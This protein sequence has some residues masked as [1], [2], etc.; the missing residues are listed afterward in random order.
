MIAFTGFMLTLTLLLEVDGRPLGRQL[1]DWKPDRRSRPNSLS[2]VVV[3]VHTTDSSVKLEQY[4]GTEQA[5][6]PVRLNGMT[7]TILPTPKS[8]LYLKIFKCK[9][10]PNK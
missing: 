9:K 6:S 10:G 7:S 4:L 3:E 1:T 5:K 2:I 8:Q